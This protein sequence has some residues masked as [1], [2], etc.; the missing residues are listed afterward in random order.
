MTI[1]G[2]SLVVQTPQ[3]EWVFCHDIVTMIC[4]NS[5][6]NHPILS[7]MM[8]QILKEYIDTGIIRA[9]YWQGLTLINPR[10]AGLRGMT[11]GCS[12]ICIGILFLE[13]STVL[14]VSKGACESEQEIQ[15]NILKAGPISWVEEKGINL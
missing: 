3:N 6:L 9:N 1:G 14:I 7:K 4:A 13:N 11:P 15:K 10:F 2:H 8:V 5:V 12:Q